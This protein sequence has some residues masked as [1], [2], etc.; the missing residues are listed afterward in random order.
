VFYQNIRSPASLVTGEA[1][2]P[3]RLRFLPRFPQLR[4]VEDE[5]NKCD[6]EKHRFVEWTRDRQQADSGK[7]TDRSRDVSVP[8]DDLDGA[9]RPLE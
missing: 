8:N 1:A 3:L 4:A 2:L 5:Q 6:E 7:P 9:G